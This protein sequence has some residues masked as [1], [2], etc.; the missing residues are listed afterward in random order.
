MPDGKARQFSFE[1][2][3]K[4]IITRPAGGQKIP[5][6]AGH[7]EITGLA[8]S[9]RGKIQRWRFRQTAARLGRTPSC[10]WRL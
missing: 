9:G 4:S 7:Y 5:G 2:E 6:G 10:N 8:W 1:L 3:A